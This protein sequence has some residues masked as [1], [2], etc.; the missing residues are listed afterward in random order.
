MNNLNK[1]ESRHTAA[2][3]E[4]DPKNMTTPF[5]SAKLMFRDFVGRD[6][7]ISYDEWLA[8]PDDSKVAALYVNFYEQ[9]TLAWY[10]AKSF[11]GEDEEG[12]ETVI[13]YLDKNVKILKENPNRYS[14]QYIYRVAYNC[15]YCICHDRKCDKD[16]YEYEC[17]NIVMQDGEELNLFDTVAD[18]RDIFE[19]QTI[20]RRRDEF[21]AI[22]ED[23]DKDTQTVIKEIL[24]KKAPSKKISAEARAEIFTNLQAKLGRFLNLEFR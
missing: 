24:E 11:Y 5:Y 10:K 21:W 8:L 22:L 18:T 20:A 19:K 12:V 14:K 15:L 16:R 13:Q 3:V 7:N 6:G 17:S 2:R 1:N 4:L 23:V 9:I